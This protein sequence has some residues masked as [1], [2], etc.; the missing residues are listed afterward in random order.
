MKRLLTLTLAVF[1]IL[2][3]G[4]SWA[5]DG[6]P[7]LE[8]LTVDQIASS[9]LSGS[10]GTLITG[11]S[12]TSNHI[13]VWNA[14]GDIVDSSLIVSGGVIDTSSN[15]ELNSKSSGNRYAFIDFHGDDTYTD[16][17]L[18][19]I[20]ANTGADA[21]SQ[22]FHR[23]TGDL[24]FY[25]QEAGN[26]KF[27]TASAIRMN[28]DSTGNIVIGNA[29]VGTSGV[30]VL[31]LT[32]GTAPTSSPADAVQLYTEDVSSS[33]ELKVR[34]EAGNITTLSP[35]NFSLFTP[36]ASYEFPWSYYSKNEYIGK[37]INVDMYGA[38][39]A[40]E[41]LSGKKFI[42]TADILKRDWDA[43]QKVVK[44]NKD[45]QALKEALEEEIEIPL[46]DAM[47]T[48]EETERIETGK[49]T[50]IS[51]EL[52]LEAG[53]VKKVKKEVPVYE[54][55]PTGKIKKQLKPGVRFDEATGKFFRKKTKSDVAIT[56]YIK[57]QPPRWIQNRIEKVDFSLKNGEVK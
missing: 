55:Q 51:Y 28:I 11:T 24:Q 20:R 34:D 31:M 17:A 25:M 37:E 3:I 32:N 12:G 16:Y 27:Y 8:P 33:S 39:K 56:P 21:S 36:D 42:Y 40:I 5:V 43:D 57:N 9:D 22:L 26:M 14:D 53:E 23:G 44:K 38:V 41:E 2:G 1:L 47:E 48:V 4:T 6:D 18:R 35:H 45:Q 46:S 13:A 10:D 49:K 30:R 50:E 29:A 7:I 54:N 52:D 15:I 19:L